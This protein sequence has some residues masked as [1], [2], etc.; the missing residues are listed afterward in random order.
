MDVLADFRGHAQ[1]LQ[2]QRSPELDAF[3]NR[4]RQHH[5][6]PDLTGKVRY[7]GG[8]ISHPPLLR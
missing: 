3:I 6:S 2:I 4:I 1:R 8:V 7:G 5:F